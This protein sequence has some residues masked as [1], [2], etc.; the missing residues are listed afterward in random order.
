MSVRAPAC[1]ASLWRCCDPIWAVDLI[2]PLLRRSNFLTHSVDDLGI[3]G[4]VVVRRE[5]AEQVGQTTMTPWCRGR[6]L[7]LD[8]L[9]RWCL[10]ADE[11]RTGQILAI[12]GSLRR[13]RASMDHRRLVA[14][15]RDNEGR[16]SLAT[17]QP[18]EVEPTTVV[19]LRLA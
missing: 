4:R 1:R 7:P 12:E 11:A 13:P 19:R 2:E 8:R 15:A 10:P 18:P 16:T 17:A 14:G 6:S 3:S 9:I 5:R